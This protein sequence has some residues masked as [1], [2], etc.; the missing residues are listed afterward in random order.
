MLVLMSIMR[1]H[2]VEK[3]GWQSEDLISIFHVLLPTYYFTICKPLHFSMSHLL[4]HK[5]MT[6]IPAD[7]N[8]H[9]QVPTIC[10]YSFLFSFR[11]FPLNGSTE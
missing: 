1:D 10:T 8:Y 7:E 2:A 9:T 4:P 6:R 3:M 5:S 11:I